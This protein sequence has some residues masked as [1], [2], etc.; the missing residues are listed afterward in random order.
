MKQTANVIV[1]V[2]L[3]QIIIN[4]QIKAQKIYYTFKQNGNKYSFT[5]NFVINTEPECL[6]EKLYNYNYLKEYNPDAKSVELV[7]RGK[8]WYDVTY[9]YEIMYFY[10]S[11]SIWRRTIIPE[12]QMIEYRMLSSTGNIGFIPKI[13][14][15]YGYY[16]VVPL[17]IGCKIIYYQE[18]EI[19]K[20]VAQDMYAK[21]AKKSSIDFMKTLKKFVSKRCMKT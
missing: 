2:L 14:S 16:K 1:I 6:L 20:S 11:E 8:N 21:E 7:Q 18:C 9:K 4:F 19:E 5:G 17:T 13:V 10:E 3:F 15:S 12:K